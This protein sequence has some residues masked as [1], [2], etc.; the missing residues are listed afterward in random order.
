M[1]TKQPQTLP[2][3]ILKQ[4]T[5]TTPKNHT[6]HL[7]GGTGHADKVLAHRDTGDGPNGGRKALRRKNLRGSRA[8]SELTLKVRTPAVDIT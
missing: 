1:T 6:T 2:S 8:V 3:N 4:A 7:S 5:K